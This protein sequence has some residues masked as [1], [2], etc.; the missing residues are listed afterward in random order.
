MIIA[1][2]TKL[3]VSLCVFRAPPLQ[4]TREVSLGANVNLVLAATTEWGNLG[5]GITQ[6]LMPS[7]SRATTGTSGLA[8]RP[9]QF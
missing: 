6:L 7:V 4:Q 1:Y 3:S 8:V 2:V 5:G 9:R